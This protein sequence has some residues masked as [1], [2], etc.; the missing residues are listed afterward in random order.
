LSISS[1]STS[2]NP[3]QSDQSDDGWQQFVQLV[4]TVNA[5]NLPA[6]QKAYESFSQSPA[7][8]VT[9]G[10]P[11]AG[12]SQALDGIGV[13]LKA[14]DIDKAQQALSAIR[15]RAH[16]RNQTPP[17]IKTPGISPAS[18]NVP[19]ATLDVTA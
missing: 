4:R 10:S 5:G 7:A 18:Q 12:V 2:I 3:R 11:S 17:S 1:V 9:Q 19:G 13:A 6:A 16:Q 15:P 14:G 8:S